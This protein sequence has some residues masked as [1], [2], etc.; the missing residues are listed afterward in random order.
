MWLTPKTSSQQLRGLHWDENCS[1]TNVAIINTFDRE[2][3]PSKTFSSPREKFYW[4]P[5]RVCK[6]CSLLLFYSLLHPVLMG[7][8]RDSTTSERCSALSFIENEIIFLNCSQSVRLIRL[9][10]SGSIP[11]TA[12]CQTAVSENAPPS[13]GWSLLFQPL[14]ICAYK[15]AEHEVAAQ[16]INSLVTG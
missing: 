2:I 4:Y 13:L 5:P 1:K 14:L 12:S 8:P 9:G 11:L 15:Y 7:I 16:H 10:G 3:M 6:W